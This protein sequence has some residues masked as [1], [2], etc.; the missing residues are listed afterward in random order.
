M[1][2]VGSTLYLC[3]TCQWER[4][5]LV[6][7]R[8]ACLDRSCDCSLQRR[9]CTWQRWWA[10]NHLFLGVVISR[11]HSYCYHYYWCNI[12]G[13][14]LEL[15]THKKKTKRERGARGWSER[16]NEN[17]KWLLKMNNKLTMQCDVLSLCEYFFPPRAMS[18]PSLTTWMNLVL[19]PSNECHSLRNS[20]VRGSV[21]IRRPFNTYTN[22]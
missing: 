17:K 13:E 11:T 9:H 14:E 15:Y 10:S 1:Q 16:E 5:L 3:T 2:L 12:Y 6:W 21:Y 7:P 19:G 8:G 4:Q 20:A 22:A 18:R